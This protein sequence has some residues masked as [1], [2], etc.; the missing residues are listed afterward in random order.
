MTDSESA[1]LRG[2]ARP[3]WAPRRAPPRSHAAPAAA[4]APPPSRG[5]SPPHVRGRPPGAGTR[6]CRSPQARARAPRWRGIV[7]EQLGNSPDLTDAA[8]E[9][10][11]I[12]PRH[13]GTEI[14]LFAL[15]RPSVHASCHPAVGLGGVAPGRARVWAGTGGVARRPR[16]TRG[17]RRSFGRCRGKAR[18]VLTLTA[19][20]RKSQDGCGVTPAAGP[21]PL[22]A[23]ARSAETNPGYSYGVRSV[24]SGPWMQRASRPGQSAQRA[25]WGSPDGVN[26]PSTTPRASSSSSASSFS[27]S[28]AS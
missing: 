8:D 10:R 24:S 22:R 23:L 5:S 13:P 28:A 9:R 15:V 14:H 26:A 18:S 27:A 2:R 6:S 25:A 4:P 7:H 12:A 19:R 17:D 20:S 21:H 16:L 11:S 3:S 1:C